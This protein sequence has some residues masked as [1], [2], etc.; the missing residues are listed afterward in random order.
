MPEQPTTIP[1]VGPPADYPVR[2]T[3]GDEQE[4]VQQTELADQRAPIYTSELNAATTAVNAVATTTFNNAVSAASSAG[5]ASASASGAA[6]SANIALTAANNRGN[7]TDASGSWPRAGE[8]FPAFYHAPSGDRA[9]WW[10]LV[11]AV[12]DITLSEPGSNNADWRFINNGDQGVLQVL[13]VSPLSGDTGVS[14][15]PTITGTGFASAR[16]E[17]RLHRQFQVAL[18][19]TNFANPVI[20]VTQNTD[21]YTVSP[22]LNLTTGY[23]SRMRDVQDLGG[24]QTLVGAWSVPQNWSTGTVSIQAPTVTVDGEPS[25]VPEQPVITSSPF[26]VTNGSDT[27]INTIRTIRRQ[28]DGV[29][30]WNPGADTTNLISVQVPAGILQPG[31]AYIFNVAYT[32]ATYG[33]GANGFKV[34]TT[35]TVFA[36]PVDDVYSAY[37]YEGDGSTR[38]IDNGIDLVNEE[39]MV[40]VKCRNAARS[41]V[42]VD[43]VR[44]ATNQLNTAATDAQNSQSGTV[45]SFNVDGFD[46]GSVNTVNNP[47]DDYVSW[48]YRK[49]PKFFDLTTINHVN[50]VQSD[51]DASSLGVIGMVEIKQTNGTSDWPVWHKDLTAGNNLRLNTT[52]AQSSTNAYAS[53]SGTT[54]SI[55]SSAP[56]GTYIVYMYAHDT[57]TE[58]GIIQCGTFTG[59]TSVNLGFEPQD[60]EY[61]RADSTG[62]WVHIDAIRGIVSDGNE[63]ELYTNL[64]NAETTSSSD[65]VT[66]TATG[67]DTTNLTGAYIFRAIRRSNKVPT[68]GT[69]V[70]AIDQG[71]GSSS[72]PAFTSGFPVDLALVRNAT[73]TDNTDFAARLIQGSGLQTNTTAAATTKADFVF[74]IMDGWFNS[75]QS[76][77]FYTWMF[78]RAPKFM[79]V[80]YDQG[81]GSARTV[82]HNLNVSPE[83]KIRTAINNTTQW[84]CWHKVMGA[85]EKI[86]L[87]SDAGK[88]TDATAWNNTIPTD[89]VFSVGASANTNANGINYITALFAT[90]DGVSKVD[91]YLGNGASQDID[92]G[93]LSGARAAAIKREDGAGDWFLWDILRGI[94][95]GNDPHLSLNTTAAQVSDDS[96]DP[97][98]AGFTVNEIPATSI[99]ASGVRYI[100]V[101]FA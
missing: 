40:T 44:G 53:V 15:T 30:V 69:E 77:A 85:D 51:Y 47:G 83:L 45:D 60:I 48:T 2:S 100:F 91:S 23:E 87:N 64:S 29:L 56:T 55:S 75:A 10:G 54:V 18:S 41:Y 92:C 1:P 93:F 49:A 89:S 3:T 31:E 74:D 66:L 13:P 72:N 14:T 39:G 65:F 71:D 50:G 99:N 25:S 84:E 26:T 79:D 4:F 38:A 81:T 17:P 61:K 98:P 68:S 52:A 76:S 36:L 63:Q 78:K 59:N 7:W 33:L 94:T 12:S 34:A 90:L 88:T 16:P 27:H 58:N 73:S 24:G 19:G 20:D 67:F 43:T 5:Q 9:G 62:N 46:V 95:V 70:F 97:L 37:A 6:D 28:S 22:A 11:R 101:A 96:I 80:V 35:S 21:S 42:R 8:D 32:G 86:V 82:N 57:D